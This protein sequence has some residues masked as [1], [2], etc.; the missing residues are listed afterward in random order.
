MVSLDTDMH[1]TAGAV[2]RVDDML[3]Y[4]YFNDEG[5]LIAL[6]FGMPKAE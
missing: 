3:Y 4:L 1:S 2:E 5:E 6:K